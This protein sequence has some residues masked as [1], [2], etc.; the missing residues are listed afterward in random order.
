[1]KGDQSYRATCSTC[2]SQLLLAVYY[3]FCCCCGSYCFCCGCFVGEGSR[4]LKVNRRRCAQF[5][6]FSWWSSL[7]IECY[8]MR[9]GPNFTTDRISSTANTEASD[10]CMNI[11]RNMFGR[12]QKW[13]KNKWPE[14]L[15]MYENTW[16]VMWSIWW[17]KHFMWMWI[18]FLFR[19]SYTCYPT[20]YAEVINN[21]MKVNFREASAHVSTSHAIQW[22]NRKIIC[23]SC[24]ENGDRAVE[25][26]L[27]QVNLPVP[28]I[29]WLLDASDAEVPSV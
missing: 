21:N 23:S 2:V 6:K 4:R 8:F 19:F 7:S 3:A 15:L 11:L 14:K 9:D 16:K 25:Q 12:I 13:K 18:D 17:N 10:E 26:M 5:R 24:E 27:E 20:V 29:Q 28:E 22:S 1:M